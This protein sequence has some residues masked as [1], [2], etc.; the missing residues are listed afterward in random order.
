[1]CGNKKQQKHM[2]CY[3]QRSIIICCCKKPKRYLCLCKCCCCCCYCCYCCYSS[4]KTHKVLS[5]LCLVGRLAFRL[6]RFF[7]AKLTQH[8][9]YAFMF[10]FLL[11]LSLKKT[12]HTHI[13]TNVFMSKKFS[14]W[15]N[16]I[17]VGSKVWVGGIVRGG[18]EIKG[19]PRGKGATYADVLQ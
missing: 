19:E 14:R 9:Y 1:M 2:N 11:S 18:K 13:Y 12:T 15:L 17:K 5:F 3:L 10:S 7:V 8:F 4:F 6:A 16:N